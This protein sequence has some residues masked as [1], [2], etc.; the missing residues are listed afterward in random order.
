[1]KIATLTLPALV[2]ALFG[3]A[4]SVAQEIMGTPGSPDATTTL[5]GNQLPAPDP[6]FGCV[7][8]ERAS[9]STPWWPPRIVPPKSAPNVLLIMTDDQGF[10]APST[11]G[12]VIPP[13]PWKA[14]SAALSAAASRFSLAPDARAATARLTVVWR[15][16]SRREYRG[17][18][19]SFALATE[20]ICRAEP[21]G[22]SRRRRT[23]KAGSGRIARE[24]TGTGYRWQGPRRARRRLPLPGAIAREGRG[25]A[26]EAQDI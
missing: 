2:L 15:K 8:K 1:M 10:G 20:N 9:E 25:S 14:I 13:L 17:M 16:T 22:Q 6:K 19:P 7:I 11:F 12:G 18:S 3:N 5:Q 24:S 21:R 23:L 4:S 26:P